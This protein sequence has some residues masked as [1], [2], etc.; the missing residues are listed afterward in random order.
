MKL[1]LSVHIVGRCT[2]PIDKKKLFRCTCKHRF[3]KIRMKSKHADGSP[4]Y[5]RIMKYKYDRNCP[6]H[7][8]AAHRIDSEKQRK[9]RAKRVIDYM[10]KYSE[11][12]D[13]LVFDEKTGTFELKQGFKED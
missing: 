5:K 4:K 12:A 8:R 6:L 7:G 9:E 3:I 13:H 11:L 1:D 2:M 10:R